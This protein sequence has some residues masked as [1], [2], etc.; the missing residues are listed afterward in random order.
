MLV[1]KYT[2]GGKSDE[3]L[4]K[5]VGN[6]LGFGNVLPSWADQL[7]SSAVAGRYGSSNRGNILFSVLLESTRALW[8]QRQLSQLFPWYYRDLFRTMHRWYEWR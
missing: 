1:S 2:I 7:C 5:S 6:G 8:R 4:V 3:K